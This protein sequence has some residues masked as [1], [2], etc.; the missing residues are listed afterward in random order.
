M[1]GNLYFSCLPL[2]CFSFSS[3]LQNCFRLQVENYRKLGF[4]EEALQ[5][6][7]LWLISQCG[8]ITEQMAE[9]IS[10]WVRVKM[11]ANKNGADDLRLKYEENW[12]MGWE[13]F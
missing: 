13:S 1:S 11:D 4:L 10:T 9:P 6:V 12:E 8:K 2:G 3:Q 5:A 7:A